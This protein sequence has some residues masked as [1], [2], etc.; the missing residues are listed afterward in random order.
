MG[1]SITNTCTTDPVSFIF[2]NISSYDNHTGSH[3]VINDRGYQHELIDVYHSED[4]CVSML[5]RQLGKTLMLNSYAIWTALFVPNSVIYVL[6]QYAPAK[7]NF[8]NLLATLPDN[9][10]A[11][12]ESLNGSIIRFKNGSEIHFSIKPDKRRNI[13][14]VCVDDYAFFT[15]KMI[16]DFQMLTKYNNCEKIIITSTPSI[17][18]TDFDTIWNDAN[19]TIQNKGNKYTTGENGYSP[20]FADVNQM[21]LQVRHPEYE[22]NMRLIYGDQLYELEHLCIKKE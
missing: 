15:Q 21:K 20:Y 19:S 7:R 10:S 17:H 11:M 8:V 22:S 4:R 18:D 1:L 5:S 16:D 12:L 6:A 2:S 13:T 9:Y 14:L 3:S